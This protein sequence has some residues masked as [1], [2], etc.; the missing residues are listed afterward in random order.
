[1]TPHRVGRDGEPT[2][3][4]LAGFDPLLEEVS[5]LDA[6]EEAAAFPGSRVARRVANAEVVFLPRRQIVGG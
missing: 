4:V 6:A 2:A 5:F 3:E 1:M